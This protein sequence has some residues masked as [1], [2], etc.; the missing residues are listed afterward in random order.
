VS[1]AATRQFVFFAVGAYP[2][3][4][5]RSIESDVRVFACGPPRSDLIARVV[6]CRD[7]LCRRRPGRLKRRARSE[8]WFGSCVLFPAFN[9]GL[10]CRV[11]RA[12]AKLLQNVPCFA[13]E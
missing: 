1:V 12:V 13:A 9:F 6:R 7:A 5:H 10:R 4:L 3:L 8:S 11:R 2:V